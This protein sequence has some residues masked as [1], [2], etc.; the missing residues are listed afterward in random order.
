VHFASSQAFGLSAGD[1]VTAPAKITNKSTPQKNT[2][3]NDDPANCPICQAVAHSGQFISPSAIVFA[4]PSEVVA[5]IPL[6]LAIAIAQE[7]ASH[8]WQSRAP[9]HH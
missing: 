6:S 3:A 4:L 9:P 8:N 1:E 2:P 7:R 5:I